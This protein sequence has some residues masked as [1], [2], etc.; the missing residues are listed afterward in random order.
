MKIA[1]ISAS[2][3]SG[4]AFV[5]AALA[6]GHVVRGG[7]RHPDNSSTSQ[8]L[9]VVT[10]DATKLE[11]VRRLVKG[12]D[13]VVSLIG[14]VKGSPP[15][16]QTVATKNVIQAM[17]EANIKRY[18]GLTGT[19]ARLPGDHQ[20]FVDHFLNFGVR[21]FDPPRVSDGVEHLK[22]L[23]KSDLDW[24]VLRVLK[25][26]NVAPKPYRLTEHGPTKW[27]VGRTEVAQAILQ[28]VE[29]HSFIRKAPIISPA[30]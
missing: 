29:E 5:K 18:V 4:Q 20:N 26:Q 6:A 30:H 23:Q 16:V 19:G 21:V 22:L 24:T 14:H 27:Y 1:V 8:N 11:D 17:D 15:D 12:Q 13:V 28:V 3:R 7:T 9:K 2:G 25:L 10:C